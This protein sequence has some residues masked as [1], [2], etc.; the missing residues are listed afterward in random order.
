M[1]GM[2]NESDAV[3]MSRASDGGDMGKTTVAPTGEIE[4][5]CREKG[6]K[7]A[8]K[9]LYDETITKAMVAGVPVVGGF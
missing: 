3:T 5:F 8:G 9:I 7:I 2:M 4:W 1:K 6:I